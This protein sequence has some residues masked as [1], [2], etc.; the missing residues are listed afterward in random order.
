MQ[1]AVSEAADRNKGPILEVIAKELAHTRHV[2]EIGSGT[3]QHAL[4]FAARLPHISWQPSD[5]GEYLPELRERIRREGSTNL[6]EVIELDVRGNPWP[7]EAAAG[8]VDGVFS[9]NTLHIMSW[10]SVQDFFRGVGRVLGIPGVLCIYG[11]FRY[12]GRYTTESNATFDDYLR[13]RDPESGIRDFEAVDELARQQGLALAADH[14]MP[15][16]N[17]LLVWHA[18]CGNGH[19]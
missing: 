9:A 18:T 11:P 12:G 2:L 14:A 10:S 7:I 19:P 5:T 13:N 6:R 16:N 1:F 15:A 17:Q 4:Y 3:G 8:P